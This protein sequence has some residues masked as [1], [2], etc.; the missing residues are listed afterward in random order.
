MFKRLFQPLSPRSSAAVCVVAAMVIAPSPV[1]AFFY[2]S[3]EVSRSL[4]AYVVC[5]AV[6]LPVYIGLLWRGWLSWWHYL[7]AGVVASSVVAAAWSGL[8]IAQSPNIHSAQQNALLT[9]GAVLLAWLPGVLVT[10]I[11]WLLVR[12]GSPVL[13]AALRGK[14]AA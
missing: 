12:K 14:N 5:I 3:D 2:M 4:W 9:V 13:A 10:F 8:A 11:G 6:G 1:A 7:L